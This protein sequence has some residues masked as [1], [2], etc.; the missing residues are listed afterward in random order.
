MNTHHNAY[1]QDGTL[2][3][4]RCQWFLLARKQGLEKGAGPEIR[5]TTPEGD[6]FWPHDLTWYPTKR[7]WADMVEEDEEE[8]KRARIMVG[9]N[10]NAHF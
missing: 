7:S 2:R 10:S 5:L 8:E 9:S 4:Q 3:L 1:V 6:I